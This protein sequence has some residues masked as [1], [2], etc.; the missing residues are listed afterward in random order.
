MVLLFVKE[1][2]FIEIIPRV[3]QKWVLLQFYYLM[4]MTHFKRENGEWVL[5]HVQLQAEPCQ[6]DPWVVLEMWSLNAPLSYLLS[7][8]QTHL[9]PYCLKWVS[10]LI[11][12]NIHGEHV[13]ISPV[14]GSVC[15]TALIPFPLHRIYIT[16]QEIWSCKWSNKT[17][18]QLHLRAMLVFVCIFASNVVSK[19]IY[20]FVSKLMFTHKN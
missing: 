15:R 8:F 3:V 9:S 2:S 13:S 1:T 11:H 18:T 10:Q 19:W 20:D 17:V 12:T 7:D 6:V 4:I 14:L 5:L 16:R